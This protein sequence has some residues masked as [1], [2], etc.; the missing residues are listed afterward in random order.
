MKRGLIRNGIAFMGAIILW[1]LV[2][3]SGIINPLFL[4][5][6]METLSQG[7]K[8]VLEKKIFLDGLYSLL[9]VFAGFSLAV[10]SG[11]PLGLVIGYHERIYLYAECLIDF[12]RSI[13]PVMTF[14]LALLAFGTGEGAR[15][16]VVYFGSFFILVLNTAQGAA[17]SDRTRINAAKLLGAGPLQILYRVVFFEALPQILTGL[18]TAL[19]LGIIVSIVTEMLLGSEYGLGSRVLYA[20]SAYEI[21]EMYFTIILVGMTG[22]L[23]NQMIAFLDYKWV[24]WN[25]EID[26]RG[27]RV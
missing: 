26:E 5:S 1:E 8:L 4:P 21:P 11:V 6:P 15:I 7:F 9:R 2:S 3:L 23:V 13:P 24:H 17:R 18:R 25:R 10:I 22:Y 12:F 19:S 14:P 27:E 16:A 20:Q